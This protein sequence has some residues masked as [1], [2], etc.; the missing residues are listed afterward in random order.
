MF[1]SFRRGE[2]GFMKIEKPSLNYE[3]LLGALLI[4]LTIFI[5]YREVLSLFISPMIKVLPDLGILFILIL[6]FIKNNFKIKLISTDIFYG[7]FLIW[8]FIS[9]VLINKV[10][11][12]PYILE[13]RSIFIYYALYFVMRNSKLNERFY[14][15]F[16]KVIFCNTIILVFLCFFEKITNK[17]MLFPSAWAQANYYPDNFVRTYGMFNNPNTFAAY[18]LFSIIIMIYLERVMDIK[19]S[20]VFYVFAMTGIILTGSRST[21]LSLAAFLIIAFILF[22]DLKVIKTFGV[23][24]ICSIIIAF[25]INNL[26]LYYSEN[27]TGE[28]YRAY[29]NN[30][31]LNAFDRF[32]ELADPNML[33]RSKSDGR[34]FSVLK[35]LEIFK[36]YPV[37]GTGFGTYGD[38]A[39]LI[40]QPKHYEE[41][42]IAEGFY[43]DNEY[44]KVLVETGLVGTIIYCLFLLSILNRYRQ[45]QVKLLACFILGFLGLFY[46]IF[47]VQILSFLYWTL[48]T[49]PEVKI[50]NGKQIQ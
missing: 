10:G 22:K 38:A 4:F 43:A 9:T 33:S 21:M 2:I 18:L 27:Y 1:I 48:L 23:I 17:F 31:T 28:K 46:N 39:S 29:M 6:Y 3:K 26:N 47:E 32:G 25:G 24:I 40:I 20:K 42:G 16:S 41:Y 36:K 13:S 14:K 44:I 15:T 12:K 8:A 37:A 35:G 7:I 50:G 49:L 34:V 11:L 45:N 30:K 19:V 5:S